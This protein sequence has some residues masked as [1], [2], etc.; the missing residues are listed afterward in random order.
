MEDKTTIYTKIVSCARV[1]GTYL[2]LDSSKYEVVDLITTY[3]NAVYVPYIIFG[4]YWAHCIV[5]YD[6][7]PE[8]VDVTV[9]YR[10]K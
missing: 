3:G 4:K 1:N 6:G 9:S 2:D 7:T 5:A 10:K 8:T